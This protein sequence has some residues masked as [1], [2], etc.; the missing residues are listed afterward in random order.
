MLVNLQLWLPRDAR[1][2]GLLRQVAECVLS[3][4]GVPEGPTDDIKLAMSEACANAVCHGDEAAEYQVS[5]RVGPE[6]CEVEVVDVGADLR[7]AA[8]PPPPDSPDVE[9]GRGLFLMRE[10]TDDMQFLRED[11]ETRVRLVKR[12]P[13]VD[14]A[15]AETAT[16]PYA[17]RPPGG[18]A[19]AR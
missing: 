16:T 15:E 7:P 8:P 11:D 10:L 3:D 9:S 19:A 2:V 1:Y 18:P 17:R 12:W 4:V 14:G 13:W 5:L 6:G